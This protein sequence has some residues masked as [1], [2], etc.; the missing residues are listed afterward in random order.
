MEIRDLVNAVTTELRPTLS[1]VF[2]EVDS[3]AR[4]FLGVSAAYSLK[5]SGEAAENRVQIKMT[6]VTDMKVP[7]GV[8]DGVELYPLHGGFHASYSKTVDSIVDFSLEVDSRSD[9][10]F[11]VFGDTVSY[12]ART[13][14]VCFLLGE[15]YDTE[16]DVVLDLVLCIDS[17]GSAA[18]FT[19]DRPIAKSIPPNEDIAYVT[20]YLPD[21]LKPEKIRDW[22]IEE[23]LETFRSFKNIL[24]TVLNE[25]RSFLAK[26]GK[27]I[28][29]ANYLP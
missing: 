28:T 7:G 3:R 17:S 26:T 15:V 13:D 5:V 10:G 11:V 2:E 24:D 6:A 21:E 9:R 22:K 20:D 1:R 29:V 25:T 16:D 23:D 18:L 14:E 12:D 19:E 4:S 8:F 27:V